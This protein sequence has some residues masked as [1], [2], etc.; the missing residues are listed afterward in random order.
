EDGSW[1]GAATKVVRGHS[2]VVEAEAMGIAA[3]IESLD[4]VE[5]RSVII[6]MDNESVVKAVLCRRY[7][8]LYWGQLVRKIRET[9]DELSDLCSMG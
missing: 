8:R 1:V 6:E 2:E 9:V 7:P 5:H 4:R 3:A